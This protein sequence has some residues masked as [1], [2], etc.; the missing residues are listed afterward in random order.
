MKTKIYP[1]EFFKLCVAALL[2]FFSF[3][4]VIP[5]LPNMLRELGGAAYLGWIIPAFSVSALIA[6]PISG[7]VT[8]NIGRKTTLIVGCAF[9]IVAGFFYPLVGTI[10]GFLFVRVVHAFSTGFTPTGFTAYTAD[11]VPSTHRGRAMGWQGLFNNAGTSLGYGLG[12][13]IAL[14]FGRDTMFICSALFALIA[15]VIF[16]TLPETLPADRIKVKP[17]LSWKRLIYVPTWKPGILMLFVCISLGSVLTIMPDYTVSLGF[18]N[19]GLYLTWY[20]AFSLL[21]R[22]ISGKISDSLGRAWSTAI[23]TGVQVLSMWV[24][25]AEPGPIENQPYFF[26]LSAVL[27]GIGQGFNAPSLFAWAGDLGGSENRGK[28]ISTLFISLELG[29]IIG[30]L[31]SGYIVAQWGG[32]YKDVFFMNGMAFGAAFLF[33]LYFI[34]YPASPDAV[35]ESKKHHSSI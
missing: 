19:K 22:L 3:N 16:Y 33:S 27:Y 5:E 30:G 12:A 4:L 28:S 15:I 35:E 25:I 34:K 23:G 11:I 6:R 32:H 10:F 14:H 18:S 26:Y 13:I 29:V 17:E 24:L 9:C 7:W 8:D 1:P 20:I 2:F 31:L 21:F